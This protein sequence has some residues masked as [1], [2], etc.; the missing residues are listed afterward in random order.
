MPQKIIAEMISG[1]NHL[2]DTTVL[3]GSRLGA[4]AAHH[5]AVKIN[6]ARMQRF[7]TAAQKE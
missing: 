5:P 4:G 1:Q 6:T 7:A 3:P 2:G